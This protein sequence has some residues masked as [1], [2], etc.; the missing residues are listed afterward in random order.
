MSDSAK[1]KQLRARLADVE[2]DMAELR[3]EKRRLYD[4]LTIERQ[5]LDHQEFDRLTGLGRKAAAMKDSGMGTAEVARALS[6]SKAFVQ[7][8][9]HHWRQTEGIA[10]TR[11]RR[12]KGAQDEGHGSR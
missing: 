5:R 10:D 2:K 8:A 3:L 11:K 9:L 12:A 6:T 7:R 4:E 1:A